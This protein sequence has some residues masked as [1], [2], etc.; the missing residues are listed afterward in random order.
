MLLLRISKLLK[1]V[2]GHERLHENQPRLSSYEPGIKKLDLTVLVRPVQLR[3]PFE[4]DSASECQ[5]LGMKQPV[6]NGISLDM[7]VL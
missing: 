3:F 5:F 2:E 7:V 4:D 1:L 6:S